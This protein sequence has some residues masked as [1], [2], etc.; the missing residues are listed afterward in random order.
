MTLFPASSPGSINADGT[1]DFGGRLLKS[2]TPATPLLDSLFTVLF[3]S[4]AGSFLAGNL[5]MLN[6]QVAYSSALL[7]LPCMSLLVVL[8]AASRASGS[9]AW[10]ALAMFA[11]VL[12]VVWLRQPILARAFFVAVVAVAAFYAI[13]VWKPCEVGWPM[14]ALMVVATVA[15]SFS[16]FGNYSFFDNLHVA[17]SGLIHKDEIFDAAIAAMIKNYGVPSV[18][19]HGLVELPYHFGSHCLAAAVSVISG[20]GTFEAYGV[21]TEG[22][23]MPLLIFSVVVVAASVA[24]QRTVSWG[25]VLA[26]ACLCM[27][28]GPHLFS[29]WAF[30]GWYINSES[31]I[32]SLSL[33]LLGLPLLF[34]QSLRW[35]DLAA[36]ALL[37]AVLTYTKPPTAAI[38]AGLWGARWLFVSGIRGRASF[39][40][41]ALAI[42][43]L[44]CV[45]LLV[46]ESDELPHSFSILD[47]VRRCSWLGVH[48]DD[49]WAAI[50]A[51]L[52][53][54]LK[55]ATL[56]G[57]ALVSFF[58]FHFFASWMVLGIIL[59][60][61]GWG[62]LWSMPVAVFTWASLLGGAAFVVFF[63]R[64]NASDVTWFTIPS[65]FVAL[66]ALAYWGGEF[67]LSRLRNERA[68]VVALI[69]VICLL[70]YKSFYRKSLWAP[71]FAG[72]E[73]SV[74]VDSLLR[75]RTETPIATVMRT[76]PDV[77]ELQPVCYGK[78]RTPWNTAFP[79]IFPA[80][81]ERPW[82]GVVR[83]E[84]PKDPYDQNYGYHRYEIDKA[85]GKPA[86]S[87]RLLPG[88]TIIDWV[89]PT[90]LLNKQN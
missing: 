89:L 28:A 44:A 41:A 24:Q 74:L 21:L 68:V 32:F 42:A 20:Q 46:N 82:I 2:V 1:D 37:S 77:H 29:R 81:S 36:V 14:I 51:G 7:A 85:T 64:A 27:S 34:L 80:I 47:Y 66:P 18:G 67:V 11:V 23:Y 25:P 55:T 39:A 62:A 12:L 72:E 65:H 75:I 90:D 87:P 56:A 73:R 4:C 35:S 88:M 6:W 26:V 69:A 50:S 45:A 16:F 10:G 43:A 52:L 59:W 83:P 63:V 17:R 9:L 3:L 15:T 86:I 19:L 49:L 5:L 70:S 78:N 40:A 76:G 53:P 71:L 54:S 33:L 58:L 13:R 8:Y 38:Y 22:F 84:D 57:I 48:I 60:R 30:M 79:F 31:A 61:H